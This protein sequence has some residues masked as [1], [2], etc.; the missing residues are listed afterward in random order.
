MVAVFHWWGQEEIGVHFAQDQ[1]A[2]KRHNLGLNPNSSTQSTLP[3]P[4]LSCRAPIGPPC[5]ALFG[6]PLLFSC[7]FWLGSPPFCF[8]GAVNVA[9]AEGLSEPWQQWL[10]LVCVSLGTLFFSVCLHTSGFPRTGT[11]SKL[12]FAFLVLAFNTL[13]N[14][15]V[16]RG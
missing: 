3:L 6:N 7:S 16:S 1:K 5:G 12:F 8:V 13:E 10:R 4:R 9:G 2:R 14:A 11:C 15:I